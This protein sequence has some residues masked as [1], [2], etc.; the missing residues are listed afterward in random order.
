MRAMRRLVDQRFMRSERGGML[1][2]RLELI[3]RI[4]GSLEEGN[5]IYWTTLCA[6]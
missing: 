2:V 5:A 3:E 4:G 6:G 1:T